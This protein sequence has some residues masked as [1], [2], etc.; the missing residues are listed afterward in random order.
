MNNVPILLP[1]LVVMCKLLYS[2]HMP[3]IKS[4][5][6]ILKQCFYG[7][8]VFARVIAVVQMG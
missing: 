3:P 1:P 6:V 7:N 5:N 2:Q 8:V 4:V